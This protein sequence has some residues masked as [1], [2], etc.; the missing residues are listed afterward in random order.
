[1]VTVS[2]GWHMSRKPWESLA[3]PPPK[4][5]AENSEAGALYHRGTLAGQGGQSGTGLASPHAV[6]AEHP[7]APN[8]LHP[9]LP[10]Q[11]SHCYGTNDTSK[12]G[13]NLEVSNSSG[14]KAPHTSATCS[15]R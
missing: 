14:P 11:P 2:C 10:S 9:L 15:T 5:Q 6:L 12:Q 13:T 1:M 7:F 3:P 8:Q 4:C